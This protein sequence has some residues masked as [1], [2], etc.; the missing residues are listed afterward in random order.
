LFPV[1]CITGVLIFFVG[2]RNVAAFSEL[3]VS[4]T[5]RRRCRVRFKV[6]CFFPELRA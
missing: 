4:H 5:F 6:T 2:H 3:L 1:P